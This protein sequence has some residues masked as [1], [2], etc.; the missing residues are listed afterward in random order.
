[1][2][3]ERCFTPANPLRRPHLLVRD[4]RARYRES[5]LGVSWAFVPPVLAA[6]GLSMAARSGVLRVGDTGLPYPVYVMFSMALWQTFVEALIGPLE[7][8][9]SAR[10]MLTRVSFPREAIL[11]AKVGEVLF[12]ALVKAV[13]IAAMF[14]WYQVEVGARVVLV[15]LA[16]LP[17]IALGMAL[18][19]LFACAGGLYQD[20]SRALPFVV[21]VWLGL[22][23]VA[24]AAP[25]EGTLALLMAVNP[26]TPLLVTV[27]ELATTEPLTM[28][29]GFA[30]ASLLALVA[31]AFSW[32]VFRVALPFVIERAS[33]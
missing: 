32:L 13:L 22:T 17:L 7:A 9:A 30:A 26:V 14:A 29:G 3:P 8:V 21:V 15:P 18:G 19:V 28:V 11:L 27:R 5:L 23:P 12:N 2:L 20:V 25:R 31:T 16:L 24:F 1:M 10:P 4:L 6:V 33:A